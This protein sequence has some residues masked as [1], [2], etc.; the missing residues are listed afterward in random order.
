MR[1]TSR[2]DLAH[3]LVLPTLLFAALG[4]MTWAVR[5]CSGFGAVA[6]CI[7]AGVTWGAAWWF[8]AHEPAG[9]Q[10]R[11]YA[12]GWIVLALTVGIGLAG[13]RG[14]MQWP[15]FF[16]GKLQTDATRGEFVPI[17]RT[18]GFLWLFIA[19]MPWAGLGACLLAWCGSLREMRAW[20]WALRIA[21][22]VGGAALARYLF[23]TYPEH[24]LPLYS[25]IAD[26]YQDLAANPNL[27][28]LI[29]DS[30]SAIQ[31]LGLYLG[32]LAFEVG[33]RD[34]KNVVLIL[35][36]GIVNGAG[37]ALCQNW[38]WA[39]SV[40]EGANFNW[41][42][43]WESSGGISIGVALGIA[44]YLVNR[45]M[46]PREQAEVAKTRALSGPNFE[47]LLTYLGLAW[48]LSLYLRYSMGGWGALYFAVVM[49][50]AA[51]YYR[52]YRTTSWSETSGAGQQGRQRSPLELGA[53]LLSGAMAGSLFLRQGRSML[54]G[55]MYVLL[56]PVAGFAWYQAN[57]AAYDAERAK[58]TPPDGDPNI[59]RWGL[60]LGLVAGLGLSLRNGLK[61]WFNIYRGDEDYWSGVLWQYLGPAYL[62]LLIAIAVWILLRPVPRSARDTRFP[63][64][65]GLV[66]LVLIVQN[67]LALLVTGPLT[68]WNEA[69]FAIYYG[70]LLLISGVI[71][72][73]YH[74]LKRQ[75]ELMHLSPPAGGIRS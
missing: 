8:I 38:K 67:T 45:R 69:V 1:S 39:P 55:Q 66:W 41:W 23:D 32:F 4:G 19:G 53:M 43:C 6:G 54:D 59:E 49:I 34:W 16:E 71:V 7:F 36:V 56:I 10:T 22:G 61:G 15:S 3:D 44:Y 70:L 14:W 60:Y 27:K 5:G 30:G 64:A 33:R 75:P 51:A 42:R 13:A 52:R 17:S 63:H 62:V 35:T 31:H 11:R 12:S 50:F 47:W 57:R 9:P 18:Y 2:H 73:H 58:S 46:S 74:T 48:F 72:F 40:W 26:R 65:Y 21:C 25:E 28:R 68:Q 37:W 29:N 24:F 20:Q